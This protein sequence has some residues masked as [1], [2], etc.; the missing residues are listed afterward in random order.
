MSA[1]LPPSASVAAPTDGPRLS[2][3]AALRNLVPLRELLVKHA[4]RSGRAL[5]IAS[6]T[7]EHVAAF[8]AALPKM[9]WHPTEPDATRRASIDAHVTDAGLG[10]VARAVALD[11]TAVGWAQDH[12]ANDLIVLI[13][14]LHLIAMPQVRTLIN[15]A[16]LALAPGGVLI[17]YGPFKRNGKL[18]S[19]GDARFDEEL[20]TADPD[21]GYKDDL[22]IA[23]LLSDAALSPID[24]TDMPA[25]NLA[26]IARK[27]AL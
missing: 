6:G 15:E 7:G 27:P 17:L 25:N 10:N 9:Y 20:R 13:N 19:A 4:P 24:S 22:D 5:E 1:R 11:A 23:A 21:I 3:P 26:F 2:A 12:P 16:A 18:T 14:L 8:A